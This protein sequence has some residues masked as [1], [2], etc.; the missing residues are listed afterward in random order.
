MP[1]NPTVTPTPLPTPTP[2]TVPTKIP[3]PSPN[4]SLITIKATTNNGAIVDLAITGNVS[5]SQ[6][7]DIVITTNQS[8]TTTTVSF[9]VTGESG[10]TG[11]SNMTIPKSAVANKTTPT[12]YIDNQPAQNQGYTQD[13]D[14]Y[15]IWYTTSFSTHKVSIQFTIP[16]KSIATSSINLLFAGIIIPEIILAFT[17]MATR[18]LRRK[19]Q[20][21]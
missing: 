21:V 7:S 2:T 11:F 20:D 19:P 15:Y 1:R 4:P 18:K 5:S 12:I 8:D 14:N 6:L 16:T 10:T 17:V 3:S 13:A 9:I